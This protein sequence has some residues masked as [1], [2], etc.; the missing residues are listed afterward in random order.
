MKRAVIIIILILIIIAIVC[1]VVFLNRNDNI[2]KSENVLNIEE[3]KI[4]LQK[5]NNIEEYYI[6]KSC[7]F[8]YYYNI[9]NYNSSSLQEDK[10]YYL[11]NVY[12]L[13]DKEYLESKNIVINDILPL[14]IY[15]DDFD[16]NIEDILRVKNEDESMYVYFVKGNLRS[17]KTNEYIYFYMIVKQDKINKTFSLLPTEYIEDK[18][19][20]DLKEGQKIEI[21][22]PEKIENKVNN[23]FGAYNARFQDYLEDILNQIKEDFNYNQERAYELLDSKQKI[24]EYKN[25]DEFKEFIISNKNEINSLNS[26]N[27]TF[28]SKSNIN[29]YTFSS[30]NYNLKI[31]VYVKNVINYTYKIIK[32]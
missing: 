28:D 9:T 2:E 21:N 18:S 14:M 29:I 27:C 1:T 15:R 3:T 23:I 13:I 5:I 24:M 12:N 10:E 17:L 4:S 32:N 16:L 11:Q 22:F 7:V 8:K 25:I 6:L 30:E 31:Q 19:I 26:S 20:F